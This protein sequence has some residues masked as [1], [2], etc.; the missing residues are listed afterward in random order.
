MTKQIIFF[1]NISSLFLVQIANILLPLLSIP[2][3][4]RIIGPEKFGLINYSGAIVGYF[5]LLVNYA[6]N[7][8]ASRRIAQNKNDNKK[9]SEIFN[10]V[11]G[12]QIIL[13]ILSFCL[14]V[15]CI[16]FIPVFQQ[17][18]KVFIV[19]YL[20]TVA[21]VFTPDWLYQGMG[22]LQ[23]L[24]F[25]NLI[26]KIALTAF[27][28]FIIKKPSDFFWQ[29][30]AMSIVQIFVT[31]T[32]L[33]WAMFK[34]KIKIKIPN[35]SILI[36]VLNNDKIIFFSS[37]IISLYTTTNVVILGSL[38]SKMEVG[39]FSAAQKFI[40]LAQSLIVM[41]LTNSLFPFIGG[42][43]SYSNINGIN[44]VKKI[45]PLIVT[46]MFF[47]GVFLLTFGTFF[48][49]EFYGSSFQKSKIIFQ[50]MA[51]IPFI[52]SISNL[53]GIQIM[54]NLKLDNVFFKITT[55]GAIISLLINAVMVRFYGGIGAA[56]AWLI[57]E[58]FITI[59]TGYYL[60]KIGIQI[61]SIKAFYPT[62]LF[63]PLNQIILKIKRQF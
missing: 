52:I 4:V 47:L 23:R 24:A 26:T 44:A 50:L 10:E 55:A 11:L 30:F 61:F 40:I 56:S 48:I 25:F 20:I 49:G 58:L 27:I 21:C 3:V 36:N 15:L 9:I 17:N 22:E 18:M 38:A 35:F 29:P 13:W 2:Y 42:E 33:N 31:F 51:F 16:F 32:S 19:T 59:S 57:T 43:F 7:L 6:F 28:I 8:T 1:K 45:A 37:I 46:L 5:I 41:P 60:Y 34:Y 39:Y 54:L 62:V 14:F 53:Y 63:A 12:C